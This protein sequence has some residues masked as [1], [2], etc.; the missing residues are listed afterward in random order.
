M[1]VTGPGP[2][3]EHRTA[4]ERANAVV[5]EYAAVLEELAAK[6]GA[7][8]LAMTDVLETTDLADDGVHIMN[9][10]YTKLTARV[11]AVLT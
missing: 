6:H 2:I 1:L 11:L 5:A 10:G 4:G 9:S 7:V 8:Y 3:V